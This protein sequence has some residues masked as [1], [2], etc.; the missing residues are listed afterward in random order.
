MSKRK[1]TDDEVFVLSPDRKPGN[2]KVKRVT[3]VAR[4]CPFCGGT[5]V[6]PVYGLETHEWSVKCEGC[7]AHGPEAQECRQAFTRWNK[8]ARETRES[9]GVM[10]RSATKQTMQVIERRV[11]V[12][13]GLN[14]MAR[15]LGCSR[16]H[17]SL[18]VHGKRTSKRL[19]GRLVNECGFKQKDLDI[20]RRS[21]GAKVVMRDRGEKGEA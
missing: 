18:V 15:K 13:V 9:E 20:V 4:N 6:L 2:L 21:A 7:R 8:K 19:M 17:L 12:A 14:E 3:L 16:G 1:L 5:K 10:K 11:T